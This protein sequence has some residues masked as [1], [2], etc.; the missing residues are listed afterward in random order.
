MSIFKSFDST[1]SANCKLIEVS[2][3]NLV[4]KNNKFDESITP[5]GAGL[6]PRLL[7]VENGGQSIIL[8]DKLNGKN[9]IFDYEKLTVKVDANATF[10]EVNKAAFSFGLEL[11]VIGYSSI[12]IGAGIASCIHGKNHFLYDFGHQVESFELLLYSKEIIKCSKFENPTIFE[13][14][15][16]GYG[17]TGFIL[18]AT[19]KLKKIISTTLQR[20]RNKVYSMKGFL[21]YFEDENLS[22]F[23]GA[24]GWHNLH[25][26][27]N[28]FGGGFIY[29][30]TYVGNDMY[31][32]KVYPARPAHLYQPSSF[33]RAGRLIFGSFFNT[34]YEIKESRNNNITMYNAYSEAISSK[35]IY[36]SIMRA[37]G[38]IET[39]FIIPYNRMED[40]T[41]YLKKALCLTKATTS[42]CITKPSSGERKYLRF[43]DK[44]VNIDITG[45][46][47]QTN[48]KFF[49]ELN[50]NINL[51]EGIPNIVKC[52]ILDVNSIE[53]CYSEQYN[54]FLTDYRR[55]IG[56]NPPSWFLKNGFLDPTNTP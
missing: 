9:F 41:V 35:N 29:Q 21:K 14:T 18:A 39:Q 44:G 46:K 36:W 19:I 3:N 32:P 25:K 30:D 12:Q 13:L 16:G 5:R 33:Y 40:F 55:A 10:A 28:G 22:S 26:R 56:K 43:R 50:S 17:S 23:Q 24:F 49:S 34:L 7:S 53:K 48:L 20:E 27:D 54:I 47:S 52:S 1:T 8:K 11:P 37:S 42:V 15:I 51:F 6:S 38:F 2:K 45:L 31:M 4:F